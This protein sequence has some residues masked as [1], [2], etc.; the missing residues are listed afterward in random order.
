MYKDKLSHVEINTREA[1]SRRIA[2]PPG[3]LRPQLPLWETLV[4]STGH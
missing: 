2:S 3:S 4:V 1:D